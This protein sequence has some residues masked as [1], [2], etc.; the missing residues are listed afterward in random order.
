MKAMRTAAGTLYTYSK[1]ELETFIRYDA[2]DKLYHVRSNIE[3]DIKEMKAKGW[4]PVH[5]S[6]YETEFI[7][8]RHAIK[9]MPAEKKKRELSEKQRAALAKNR[10][11]ARKEHTEE[12]R[13]NNAE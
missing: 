1:E 10:F 5:E 11:P 8:P 7:V 4:T 3:K 2:V 6:V 12:P 9:F 13:D